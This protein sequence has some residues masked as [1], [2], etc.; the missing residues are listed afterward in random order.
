MSSNR[1]HDLEPA[2]STEPPSGAGDWI[3]RLFFIL[4]CWFFLS[5]SVILFELG[6]GWAI[7]IA[8]LGCG[9]LSSL[10]VFERKSILS[11]KPPR[12]AVHGVLAAVAIIIFITLIACLPTINTYFM[13][14]DFAFLHAFHYLSAAQFQQLFHMDTSAFMR[15]DARQ[16]FRPLCSLFYL[17][18]YRAW[19]LHPWGYHLCLILLHSTVA[20]L[21]FF[22]AKA[23]A[24][25]DLRR[26]CL[27]A[28]LFAVQPLNA[29]TTSLIEGAVAECIP[30]ILFLTAFLCFIHFRSTGRLF[31]LALSI[32]A[33]ATCLLAKESAVTLP[34]MLASYDLFSLVIDGGPSLLKTID[35]KRISSLVWPY[36]LYCVLLFAYLEWRHKIFASYL[37]EANWGNHIGAAVSSPVGFRLHLMHFI[38]RAWQLHVF[39]FD[40][41]APFPPLILGVV[42][43]IIMFW[44]LTLFANRTSTKSM[45]VVLYFCLIWQLVSNLPYLIETHVIYHLYLPSTGICIGLGF[46]AFPIHSESRQQGGY[47]RLAGV[48]FLIIASAVQMWKGDAEYKR[49]GDM[50][51]RMAGQLADGMKSIPA[52]GLVVIW[53]AKSELIA[54]GWGEEILPYSVQPPFAAT[55][56]YS[57]LRVVEEPDMSCC[58]V[59]EWWLKTAPILGAEL[60]RPQSEEITLYALS[61]DNRTGTFQQATRVVPRSTLGNCISAVLG[62]TPESVDSI[63]EGQ[64]DRLVEALTELVRNGTLALPA[65]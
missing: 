62:G 34:L 27:A 29:Q 6:K 44:S 13:E 64:G 55:D 12:Q 19:G 11:A 47:L 17:G 63:D 23:I 7:P 53:P 39:N 48:L 10:E 4:L 33:F 30:A 31:H 60:A 65:R 42:L 37:R 5:A 43:A 36:P 1:A 58:G 57:N 56:L 51:F 3:R 8:L 9:L 45:A 22:I 59:G 49:Y 21:L 2:L 32:V 61:W 24:P 38:W 35:R 46:L 25:G 16:E 26:S 28:V 54:S 15:G 41:L 18:V 52:N 20:S 40:T 14:D 50:S